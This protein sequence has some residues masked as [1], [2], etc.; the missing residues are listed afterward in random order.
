MVGLIH[1]K[2]ANHQ[3]IKEFC[4][5]ICIYI[6]YIFVYNLGVWVCAY[7]YIYIDYTFYTMF[8]L[9]Y[10]M[11][12]KYVGSYCIPPDLLSRG[13]HAM[14]AAMAMV[15]G[16]A[17]RLLHRWAPI[18]GPAPPP[19]GLQQSLIPSRP[20]AHD[21]FQKMLGKFENRRNILIKDN[22]GT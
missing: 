9:C 6:I 14:H 22:I 20:A 11:L 7:L 2:R 21:D 4:G 17:G 8:T 1:S 18:Y 13:I 10:K 3:Y 12:I 16:T 15:L 5:C 19:A